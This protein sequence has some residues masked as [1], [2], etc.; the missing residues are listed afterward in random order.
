MF[1]L[2]LQVSNETHDIEVTLSDQTFYLLKLHVQTYIDSTTMKIYQYNQ[3]KY[4]YIDISNYTNTKQ[5]QLY[6]GK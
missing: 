4:I 5:N 3:L 1:Y 6:I 2:R